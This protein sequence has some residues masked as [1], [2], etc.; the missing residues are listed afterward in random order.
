M[1]ESHNSMS[2]PT[3]IPV[4][5]VDPDQ[6]PREKNWTYSEMSRIV[7]NL[8]LESYKRSSIMEEQFGAMID[9][10]K[11]MVAETQ[12]ALAMATE[13]NAKLKRELERREHRPVSAA[14]NTGGQNSM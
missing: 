2:T 10:Y 3:Q 11:R 6:L 14:S 4:P 8:Y 9:E 7:G 5:V 1:S 12:R 13:E